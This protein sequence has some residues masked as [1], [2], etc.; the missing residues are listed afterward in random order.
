MPELPEVE[1]VV[2]GLSSLWTGRCF[3]RIEVRRPD[4]RR[5]IPVDLAQRLVGARVQ[6]VR[7]RAKYGLV[8]TDRGDTLI[9]HLGMSGRMRCDPPRRDRHDHVLFVTDDGHVVALN[10]ARRFG[11]LDLVPTAEW[12]MHPLLVGLGPEPLGPD[13]TPDYLH[14]VC[15]ARAS[16]IKAVLLDQ[17][18]IAGIGNIYACEALYAAHIH[19]QRPAAQ[20][21]SSDSERLVQAIR[22]ILQAACQAGGSTLRDHANLSGEMGYFQ[23]DWR[24]YGRAGQACLSCGTPVARIT[25]A[26]RSSFFCPSCQS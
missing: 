15:G 11:L 26:G 17:R 4:L 25:Q 10:D 6:T 8:D 14:K 2:Q 19:P 16:M 23:H 12:A 20:I 18:L 5:P 3:T 13:L 7:R 1:T 21:D 9:F 22:T 24:V